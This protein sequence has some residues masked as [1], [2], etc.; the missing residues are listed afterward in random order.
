MNEVPSLLELCLMLLTT[1]RSFVFVFLHRCNGRILSSYCVTSM[2]FTTLFVCLLFVW[3]SLIWRHKWFLTLMKCLIK[4]WPEGRWGSSEH[5]HTLT[6]LHAHTKRYSC[7]CARVLQNVAVTLTQ[8][9]VLRAPSV[10][11]KHLVECSKPY[12][13][14]GPMISWVF[15]VQT[16]VRLF[17][18]VLKLQSPGLQGF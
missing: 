6:H 10:N 16:N 4:L 8:G 12:N 15:A 17:E 5:T 7:T 11:I 13:D 14:Q 2:F 18:C 9:D 1:N 3:A